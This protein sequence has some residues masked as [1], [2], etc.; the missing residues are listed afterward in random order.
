MP[1]SGPA[2]LPRIAANSGKD[3]EETVCTLAY[4]ALSE[5]EAPFPP[6]EDTQASDE[7]YS[8]SESEEKDEIDGEGSISGRRYTWSDS[9]K[10]SIKFCL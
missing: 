8:D 3:A 1:D 4:C 9:Y 7:D 10:R 2:R 5:L 6:D